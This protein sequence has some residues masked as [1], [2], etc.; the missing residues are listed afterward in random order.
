MILINIKTNWPVEENTKRIHKFFYGQMIF[1]K[2]S[3]E[4]FQQGM[5]NLFNKLYKGKL[6]PYV[7]N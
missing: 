7:K 4:Q 1:D 6:D 5:D 3:Y 2:Q